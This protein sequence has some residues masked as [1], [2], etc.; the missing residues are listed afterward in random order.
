MVRGMVFGG[1]SRMQ[2]GVSTEVAGEL[3]SPSP[4]PLPSNEGRSES[5]AKPPQSHCKAKQSNLRA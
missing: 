1:R 2:L 3:E 4:Y 5:H